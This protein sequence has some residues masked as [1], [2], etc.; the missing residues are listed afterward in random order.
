MGVAGDER[1]PIARSDARI[2]DQQPGEAVAPRRELGVGHADVV[3]L[4]HRDA[5][6]EQPPGSRQEV[7]RGERQLHAARRYG[8]G[9]ASGQ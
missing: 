1:H 2:I 4:H 3:G 8:R 6:G 9:P 5:V 7:E